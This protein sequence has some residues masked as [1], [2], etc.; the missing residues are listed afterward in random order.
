VTLVWIW[1][2]LMP[3]FGYRRRKGWLKTSPATHYP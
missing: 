3:T 1:N 2:K